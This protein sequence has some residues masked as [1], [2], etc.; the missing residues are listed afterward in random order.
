MKKI[1]NLRLLLVLWIFAMALAAGV[2]VLMLL[3]GPATT[4]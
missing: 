3:R 4:L 1:S 2:F